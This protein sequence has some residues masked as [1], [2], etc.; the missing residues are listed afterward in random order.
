M[1]LQ[2]DT[3]ALQETFKQQ[4]AMTQ[5]ARA[6]ELR[7][8]PPISARIIWYRQIER[9]LDTYMKRVEAVLGKGWEQH[10]DGRKLKE[11]GDNFRAKI[12]TVALF[13]EWVAEASDQQLA[14]TRPLFKV[15]TV[16]D[17]AQRRLQLGVAF[18]HA[19]VVLQKETRN[20]QNL[21]YRIPFQIQLT[22]NSIQG[23]Y[24]YSVALT[25]SLRTYNQT[26]ATVCAEAG[27]DRCRAVVLREM[28]NARIVRA[29]VDAGLRPLV[30][31][32]QANAQQTIAEG[33]A[34]KWE[35]HRLD[36][37]AKRLART[38]LHFQEKVDEARDMVAKIDQ[39]LAE[40]EQAEATAPSLED[41][42]AG[43]QAVVDDLSLKS[44]SNITYAHAR[45][46]T[47]LCQAVSI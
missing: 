41:I 20:L 45:K 28:Y 3:R 25:D 4:Y 9:Q 10:P 34:L 46:D 8:I 39:C 42:L 27:R 6:S 18:D 11:E 2:D 13:E 35:S 15:E 1:C 47:P 44:Y 36:D 14:T 30:A 12:N 31:E 32:L 7:D 40:L 22:A 5:A 19:M 26:C 38:V 17:G 43:I 21:G 29:Q 23:I 37:Y 33:A 16:R 24:P